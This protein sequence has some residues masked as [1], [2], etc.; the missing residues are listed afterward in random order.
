M[1]AGRSGGRSVRIA[2][3]LLLGVLALVTML[4]I[5]VLMTADGGT[6]ALNRSIAREA[7][8]PFESDCRPTGDGWRCFVHDRAGSGQARYRLR[9]DDDCWTARRVTPQHFTELPMPARLAGCVAL[10]DRV[11]LFN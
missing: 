10:R 2:I 8:S 5:I 3:A 1:T 4:A 7:N 11:D 9:K 6:T